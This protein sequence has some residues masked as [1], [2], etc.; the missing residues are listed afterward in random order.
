MFLCHFRP[1]KAAD[2]L[3]SILSRILTNLVHLSARVRKAK[4]ETTL[5]GTIIQFS[6]ALTSENTNTRI[7]PFGHTPAFGNPGGWI[8]KT[9]M[10]FQTLTSHQLEILGNFF[11]I[12]WPPTPFLRPTSRFSGPGWS[13]LPPALQNRLR[14]PLA[15]PGRPDFRGFERKIMEVYVFFST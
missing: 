8:S 14:P 13:E 6:T 9:P 3:G 5:P 7:Y 1:P 10:D 4:P 12:L 15:W 11:C 2:F